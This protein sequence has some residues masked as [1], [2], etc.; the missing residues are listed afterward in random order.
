M[1]HLI[2]LTD[3]TVTLSG[4]KILNGINLD[5]KAGEF[6]TLLGPSGCGKTTLLRILSGHQ[7]MD[8]GELYINQR[9]MTHTSAEQ[10]PIHTVFQQ[11]ALFPH[12]TVWQNVAF[13]LVHERPKPDDIADRVDAMLDKVQMTQLSSHYPHQLSGGQQQRVAIARAL[14]KQPKVLLLDEPMSALDYP[15]RKA[16]RMELKTLQQTLG[17]AF[18]LVTHDQEEAL[19]LADRVA[20]MQEGRLVQIDTPRMIYEQPRTPRIAR[21][22]GEANFFHGTVLHTTQTHLHTDIEGISFDFDNPQGFQTNQ[23]I[24]V[25]VRPEDLSVWHAHE[26]KDQSTMISAHVVQVIYKG[27]TVD[28]VLT[29][30]SG[31]CINATEFFDEQDDE[32]VYDVGQQVWINWTLGWEIIFDAASI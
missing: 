7:T 31:Q 14:I 23:T 15:L 28:L 1:T 21:F 30:P 25:M 5:I 4:K 17:I 3:A 10:R 29:L 20:V 11:Y 13:G 12:L 24:E 8:H 18:V 2:H 9:H 22:I 19:S 27:S 26:T 16:M 6:F 32:L